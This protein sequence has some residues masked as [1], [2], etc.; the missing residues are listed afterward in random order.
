MIRPIDDE[1]RAEFARE[2]LADFFAEAEN[3]RHAKPAEMADWARRLMRDW[4]LYSREQYQ[5]LR[6]VETP[7]SA[8]PSPPVRRRWTVPGWARFWR[9]G[10]K[11]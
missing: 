5:A 7:H 1:I 4:E 3:W 6:G 9:A 8:D 10:A 2:F 11:A